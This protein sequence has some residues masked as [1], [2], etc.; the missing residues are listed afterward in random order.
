MVVAL[1]DQARLPLAETVERL[2]S[3]VVDGQAE[4]GRRQRGRDQKGRLE[5]S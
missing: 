5:N 4:L 2:V 3:V 1:T